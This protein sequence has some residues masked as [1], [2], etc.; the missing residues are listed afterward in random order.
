MVSIPCER[1]RFLKLLSKTRAKNIPPV[2]RV[3]AIFS[4]TR[5]ISAIQFNTAKLASTAFT[6]DSKG[7]ELLQFLKSVLPSSIYE[8]CEAG[9]SFRALSIASFR[10]A[11][12]GSQKLI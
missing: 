4:K 6:L 1:I 12:E 3:N 5:S 10:I 9:H 7:K 11:K 2:F 8:I